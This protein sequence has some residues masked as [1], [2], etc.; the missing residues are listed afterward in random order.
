MNL[1]R[2]S[3]CVSLN[4]GAVVFRRVAELLLFILNV[5]QPNSPSTSG[6]LC[7]GGHSSNLRTCNTDAIARSSLPQS[8]VSFRSRTPDKMP[9]GEI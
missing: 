5:W 4:K 8:L 1:G 6:R 3:D 2:Q 9:F 7:S